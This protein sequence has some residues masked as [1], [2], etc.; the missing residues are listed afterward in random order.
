MA[1][2]L[3][4]RSQSE[5]GLASAVSG[6]AGSLA[7]GRSI[8]KSQAF[9]AGVAVVCIAVAAVVTYFTLSGH[10]D[11]GADSRRRALIDS[12]T[13]E[14]FLDYPIED[15]GSFPYVN[16][17]TGEATLY[18]VERCFW[19]KDGKAKLDPTFVLLN[20]YAG[21]PGDT[22]CP[23]CGRKVVGH[24]PRPPIKMM[25]EAAQQAGGSGGG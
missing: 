17:K 23:D 10:V 18:P 22:L 2:K 16:R 19:T 13:L 20:E 24:N 3:N 7:S 14:V 4:L 21:K 15:G 25:E 1:R 8:L 9:K 5:G 12:K 11:T 6:M